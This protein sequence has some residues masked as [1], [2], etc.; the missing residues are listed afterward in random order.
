M[1]ET[2]KLFK[3]AHWPEPEPPIPD[4][5][6]HLELMACPGLFSTDSFKHLGHLEVLR[7]GLCP[8]L[9]YVS[10]R[11]F[12]HLRELSL[13]DTAVRKLDDLDC[14][15]AL[16]QAYL[17]GLHELQRIGSTGRMQRALR[18]L[19]ICRCPALRDISGLAS[20]VGL[21]R[22]VLDELVRLH[23]LRPLA[24]LHELTEI[25][26]ASCPSLTSIAPLLQIPG[27][28]AISIQRCPSIIDADLLPRRDDI[29]IE[30]SL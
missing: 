30:V 20:F 6:R 8:D 14:A 22:L 7:L 15:P 19:S 29:Q 18:K 24:G 16:E 3:L 5:V 28:R 17:A 9:I 21:G 13:V 1:L 27:L 26:I 11:R 23:D 25:T 10:A 12:A 2:L 4:T